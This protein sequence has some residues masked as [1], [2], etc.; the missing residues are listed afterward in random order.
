MCLGKLTLFLEKDGEKQEFE[1]DLSVKGAL[2]SVKKIKQLTKEKWKLIDVK[3]DNPQIVAYLKSSIESYDKSPKD[4]KVPL[5]QIVKM[6]KDI[7]RDEVK[8]PKE[9]N[10]KSC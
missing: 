4:F 1:F 5:V 2:K 9:E 10:N 3:G 7:V 8:K 6:A